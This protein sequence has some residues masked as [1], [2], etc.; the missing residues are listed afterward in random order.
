MGVE[1]AMSLNF[2][3]GQFSKLN[4]LT[5]GTSYETI[6]LWIVTNN[7]TG[8]TAT[9]HFSSSTAMQRVGGDG[10]IKNYVPEDP[11]KPDYFFKTPVNGHGFAY[12][13]GDLS[14]EDI[15]PFFKNTG[16][17]CGDGNTT[18]AFRCWYNQ[19]DATVPVL[20]LKRDT[21]SPVFDERF[22]GMT[23]S[24]FFGVAVGQNPV[25]YLPEGIYRATATITVLPQ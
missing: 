3:G 22:W 16:S 17:V 7:P 14:T 15:V 9:L 12:S 24:I 8:Y 2:F 10:H 21:A 11:S 1:I 23:Y 19:P 6:N 13:F 4:G 20:F 5:G 25:P 18:N